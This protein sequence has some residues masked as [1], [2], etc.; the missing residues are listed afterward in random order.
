MPSPDRPSTQ[1]DIPGSANYCGRDRGGAEWIAGRCP[2]EPPASFWQNE[3]PL[4]LQMKSTRSVGTP[5]QPCHSEARAFA[6]EPGIHIRRSMS[7]THRSYGIVA[8]TTGPLL[9]GPVVQGRHFVCARRHRM[10]FHSVRAANVEVSLRLRVSRAR[11]KMTIGSMPFP[12]K[13]TFLFRR[14]TSLFLEEQGS[15]CKSL[16]PFGD[17]IAAPPRETA[18]G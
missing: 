1:P 9:C 12:R 7:C 11:R 13:K 3:I 16:I 15:G 8:R 17:R 14:K 6:R 4:F 10:S 5:A 2:R 18:N